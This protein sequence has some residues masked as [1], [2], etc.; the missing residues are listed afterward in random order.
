[1]LSGRLKIKIKNKQI[2]QKAQKQNQ[3]KSNNKSINYKPY[4]SCKY[5]VNLIKMYV[6]F[7]RHPKQTE[8]RNKHVRAAAD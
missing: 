8:T 4:E 5:L 1:M 6:L 3:I 2:L 7:N